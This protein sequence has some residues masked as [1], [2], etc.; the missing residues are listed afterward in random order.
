MK[1]AKMIPS[2]DVY[3]ELQCLLAAVRICI[4]LISTEA[5]DE[6]HYFYRQVLGNMFQDGIYTSG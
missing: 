4:S 1:W 3:P 2:I 5:L 6:H